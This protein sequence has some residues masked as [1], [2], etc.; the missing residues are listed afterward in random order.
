[1]A[2]EGL[3]ESS[4]SIRGEERR[5]ERGAEGEERGERSAASAARRRVEQEEHSN[6]ATCARI[7][8]PV[9]TH[10]TCRRELTADR[11][12]L[13]CSPPAST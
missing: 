3:G 2:A 5:K 6:V 8:Q 13:R 11:Q 7:W 4:C 10:A 9:K 12:S 1:M